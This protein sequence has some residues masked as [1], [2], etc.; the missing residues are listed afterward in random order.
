MDEFETNIF[1]RQPVKVV[2]D[3]LTR[4]DATPQWVKNVVEAEQTSTGPLGVGT[5]LNETAKLAWRKI[6]VNWTVTDFEQDARISYQGESFLGTSFISYTFEQVEGGTK[7]TAKDGRNLGGIGSRKF[8]PILKWI[9]TRNRKQLL[10][11]I[12]RILETQES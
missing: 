7:I 2:F 1:I 4:C 11:N 5:T 8:L 9:A 3:Y 10:R 6:H 12:K